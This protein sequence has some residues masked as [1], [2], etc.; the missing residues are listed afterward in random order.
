MPES[1]LDEAFLAQGK[2][3]APDRHEKIV[4]SVVPRIYDID[5]PLRVLQMVKVRD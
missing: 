2:I 4:G 5:L 3:Y 1:V